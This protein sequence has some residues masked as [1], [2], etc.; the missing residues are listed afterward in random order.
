M[1]VQELTCEILIRISSVSSIFGCLLLPCLTAPRLVLV[2]QVLTKI[3]LFLA[4]AVS[5]CSSGCLPCTSTD[6][7]HSRDKRAGKK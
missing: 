2:S 1:M 5:S 4:F 6:F 3:K 7:V